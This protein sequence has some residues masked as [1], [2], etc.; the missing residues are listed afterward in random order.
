MISVLVAEDQLRTDPAVFVFDATANRASVVPAGGSEFC[1]STP[2]RGEWH[3]SSTPVDLGAFFRNLSYVQLEAAEAAALIS[4]ATAS[5]GPCLPSSK[6]SA[7][8]LVSST[9]ERGKR[10][11]AIFCAACPGSLGRTNTY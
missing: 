5:G 8:L 3:H 11:C 1:G 6:F 7:P 4:P 2:I 10:A 9:L